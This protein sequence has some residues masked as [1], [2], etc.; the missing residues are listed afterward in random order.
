MIKFKHTCIKELNTELLNIAFWTSKWHY[1]KHVLYFKILKGLT[2]ALICHSLCCIRYHF[3]FIFQQ[4][5]N[6]F[7]VW[8]CLVFLFCVFAVSFS[9]TQHFFSFKSIFIEKGQLLDKGIHIVIEKHEF[10]Q[11]SL[12]KVVWFPFDTNW[13]VSIVKIT[14]PSINMNTT[15][16]WPHKIT[17]M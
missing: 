3:L 14:N 13:N 8:V 7:R 17:E 2:V 5:H 16:F 15:F 9:Y 6:V 10:R 1:L 11:I 4:N 12:S